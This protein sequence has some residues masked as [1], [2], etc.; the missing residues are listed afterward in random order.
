MT[1]FRGKRDRVVSRFY[2]KNER[3]HTHITVCFG[4]WLVSMKKRKAR[5]FFQTTYLVQMKNPIESRPLVEDVVGDTNLEVFFVDIG[6]IVACY[7]H[8]GKLIWSRDILSSLGFGKSIT[9][10]SPMSLGDV[11]GDG[12]LDLVMTVEVNSRWL[13]LAFQAASGNDL[14]N[15]PIE[16][17]KLRKAGKFKNRESDEK[18]ERTRLAQPLL[19]DLHAD[20]HYILDYIRRGS[21][22]FRREV[23]IAPSEYTQGGSSAGIHIVQ[24]L[25]KQLYIVEGGSGCTQ[26]V[27]IGEE[28]G[29]MVE[30]DDIHGTNHLDLLV[31]TKEG[32][33]VTLESSANYHPL[34]T[35]TGGDVRGKNSH[36]HGYSASQGI[37]VHEVSRQYKDIFG[38]YVPVTFEVFDN[39]PNIDQELGKRIYKIEVRVGSSSQRT[40][41][42]VEVQQPGV[43]TERIYVRFG[44]GYYNLCVLMS[45]SHGITYEDCFATGYNV[46]FMAG[47]GVMLWLPLLVSF[48]TILLCSVSKKGNWDDED[49][50]EDE[51]ESRDNRSL[52]ILGRALPT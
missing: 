32:N 25:E 1:Q 28:I 42:R 10:A 24:P 44:P 39:R 6:G 34:N 50:A 16:L 43:Y 30:V 38:V 48:V 35:W 11:D 20:Q 36:T 40:L 37:F 12:Y 47:F 22:A 13:V 41:H 46:H 49:G 8:E 26:K 4:I 7:S 2:R 21:Q 52:G 23:D 19:V 45:T 5:F 27:V 3:R 31:A 33:I 51:Q 29:T 15:F 17:E 18:K 14:K 9:G